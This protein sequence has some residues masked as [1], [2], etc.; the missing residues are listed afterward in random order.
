[1]INSYL[2]TKDA[3]EYLGVSQAFLAHKRLEG[4]GPPYSKLGGLRAAVRYSKEDLD[5]WMAAHRVTSTSCASQ[6]PSSS[7]SA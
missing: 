2:S 4:G 5:A 6:L 1:M 7:P 3:A